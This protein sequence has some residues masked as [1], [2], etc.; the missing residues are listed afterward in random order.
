MCTNIFAIKLLRK[1]L[2]THQM[3]APHSFAKLNRPLICGNM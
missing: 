3:H 1:Y 2:V